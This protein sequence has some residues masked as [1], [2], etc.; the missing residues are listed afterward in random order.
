[1]VG[2]SK[3]DVLSVDFDKDKVSGVELSVYDSNLLDL[4][5][6]VGSDLKATNDYCG[7][8][9]GYYICDRVDLHELIGK[10]LG[11][12][13]ANKVFVH[14][15]HFNCGKPLCPVCYRGSWDV[16]Q[17]R[18]METR[19]KA[20]SEMLKKSCPTSGEI[21]HIV[22]SISPK[23]Y[24]IMDEKVLRAK[25]KKA[26]EELGFIGGG[27]IFHGSRHR[28]YE[29][30]KGGAFRQI[31]TDWSPHYH[32]LGF[33]KDGYKCRDCKRKNNC[34][35]GCG[36]F[37]DRRWQ[38]YLKTG[39]YVKVLEKRKT[40]G[41][42]AWYQLSHASVR[43]GAKRSHVVTWMGICGYRKMK[44][45]IEKSKQICPICQHDLKRSLYNGNKHFVTNRYSFDYV[46]DSLED[47]KEDGMIVWSDAPKRS[48]V[49][50]SVGDEPRYGFVE[51]LK[52]VRHW[53]DSYG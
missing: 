3:V 25:A 48:F 13:Y 20:T 16:R 24:G 43:K 34:L 37:D 23:D 51:W 11:K 9:R 53:D 2:C 4:Y 33:L 5:P 7:N 22:V 32:I 1:M 21:E 47:Y 50:S 8:F 6:L 46:Q 19:L 38:Y 49:P 15:V 52:S 10:K 14:K 29:Q 44:V 45:K 26:L 28:R 40:I 18:K 12:D 30:I 17:A 42:T 35:A 36:G 39:I 41:G 27:F 31:G